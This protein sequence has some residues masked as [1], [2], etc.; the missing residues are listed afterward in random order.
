MRN[1]IIIDIK[2][3]LG[4]QLFQYARG[5]KLSCIDKE[6]VIFNTSFFTTKTTDTD[7]PFLLDRFN[8]S[9]DA[10][11]ENVSTNIL[12]RFFK[13]IFQKITG[14]YGFYQSEKFFIEV[15]DKISTQ[16]TLKDPLSSLGQHIH[17]QIIEQSNPVA[18]HIRRGDYVQDQ[19][20]HAH[21]G[22]CTLE[23][24]RAAISYIQ[25]HTDAP[26]FFIFSDDI[27]WVKQNLILDHAV[28][29]SNPSLSAPEE[30]ILMSCCSHII[31]ANSTFSWWAAYLNKNQNKIVIAPKQWTSQK[32]SEEL[33][34]LPES[35]IQI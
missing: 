29:V 34:I 9:T 25:K 21:H 8:I 13:K 30:L 22:T 27:E 4:N 24:Y 33:G 1:N 11:F 19:K 12:Q 6:H 35:W 20:T 28:Y 15:K 3:G 7:R 5:C 10:R 31:I 23:Y 16:Y 18:I 26:S 14:D 2:G 32:T 17:D